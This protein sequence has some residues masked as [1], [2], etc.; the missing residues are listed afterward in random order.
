MI[1]KIKLLMVWRPDRNMNR[2]E[3]ENQAEVYLISQARDKRW[4]EL[5]YNG[6][7]CVLNCSSQVWLFCDPMGCSPPGSSVH[8]ILQAIK[9][10]W[11]AMPSSRDVPNPGVKP[12]SLTSPALAGRFFTTS[13]TWEAPIEYYSAKKRN[14]V[15]S[16]VEMWMFV[17]QSEIGQKEKQILHVNAY[18]WNL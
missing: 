5:K 3:P 16:F 6:M 14:K 11:I 12:M 8:E 2:L 10:E 18:M 9:L 15:R 13:T 4:C 1:W 7:L 17:I